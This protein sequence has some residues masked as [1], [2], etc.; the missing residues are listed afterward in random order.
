MFTVVRLLE[1]IHTRAS[2]QA[3]VSSS[4]LYLRTSPVQDPVLCGSSVTVVDLDGSPVSEYG[5]L[6]VQAFLWVNKS[7]V[8]TEGLGPWPLSARAEPIWA[9]NVSKSK[10]TGVI[11]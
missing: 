3:E 5:S 8:D 10:L 4:Q 1:K 2:I 11:E 9:T 7:W 6:D